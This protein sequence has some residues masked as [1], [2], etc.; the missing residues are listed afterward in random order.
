M[1]YDNFIKEID[2]FIVENDHENHFLKTREE[3]YWNYILHL[4][5]LFKAKQIFL[6]WDKFGKLTA[7]CGWILTN[8]EQQKYINKIT[9][10][11]P[12]EISQGEILY[13]SFCIIK[14]GK[15]DLFKK[16]FISLLADKVN[17]V[18]WFDMKRNKYFRIKNI[19][20]KEFSY[21]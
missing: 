5:R 4:S 1:R 2:K 15:M 14:D 16:R 10:E 9:W 8:K 13:I 12:K 18:F 21:V 11:L 17:E 20:K 19:Y 3:Y 7:V 6:Q